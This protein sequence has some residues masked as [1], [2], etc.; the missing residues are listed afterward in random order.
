MSQNSQRSA[1]EDPQPSLDAER[2]DQLRLDA[3]QAIAAA[4]DGDE[5]AAAR[6]A[7]VGDRSPLALAN[8][9][10]GQLPG[11]ERKEAGQ[12]VGAARK[13]VSEA[14]EAR[15]VELEAER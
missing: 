3:L 10:I 5:L 13:A 9:A 6:H 8:R 11:P 1:P 4:A 12:R 7:H 15:Q 14:Y 2:I